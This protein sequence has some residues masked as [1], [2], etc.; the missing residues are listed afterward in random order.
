MRTDAL[1]LALAAALVAAPAAARPQ[2]VPGSA[3]LVKNNSA[4]TL[5]CRYRVDEGPWLKY[6]AFK[7]GA[8]F[9]LRQPPGVRAV[10]FFC[11]PPVKRVSYRLHPGERYSLLPAAD[12]GLELR[13][14]DT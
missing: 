12:G 7:S 13:D 8:E 9:S 11:D 14:I 2:A 3:F 1:R 6:F 10:F 5:N 4:A